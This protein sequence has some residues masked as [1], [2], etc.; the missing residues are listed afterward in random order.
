LRRIPQMDAFQRGR[1]SD[2][3]C[4]P[5]AGAPCRIISSCLSGPSRNAAEG[6]HSAGRRD[7]AFQHLEWA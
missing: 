2:S 4:T 7:R 3:D 6:A 1:S 5:A